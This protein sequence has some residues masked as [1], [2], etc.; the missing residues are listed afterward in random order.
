MEGA[1]VE[2]KKMNFLTILSQTTG[3]WLNLQRRLL[4]CH[5]TRSMPSYKAAC[6]QRWQACSFVRTGQH[7]NTPVCLSPCNPSSSASS[8]TP[9]KQ[10]DRSPMWGGGTPVVNHDAISAF[11]LSLR[12]SGEVAFSPSAPAP[13]PISPMLSPSSALTTTLYGVTD[14]RARPCQAHNSLR[15]QPATKGGKASHHLSISPALVYGSAC[16]KALTACEQARSRG[17]SA[18]PIDMQECRSATGLHMRASA[19]VSFQINARAGR[20]GARAPPVPEALRPAT[21]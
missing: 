15:R 12:L 13:P 5:L 7:A 11:M 16:T 1:K 8:T 18:S 17:L 3:T 10:R 21:H 9:P 14:L 6:S 20:R 4:G 2:N 19:V